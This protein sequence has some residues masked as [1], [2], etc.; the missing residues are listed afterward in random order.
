MYPYRAFDEVYRYGREANNTPFGAIASI[1]H[2]GF[3]ENSNLSGFSQVEWGLNTDG[4]YDLTSLT[5]QGQ[6]VKLKKVVTRIHDTIGKATEQLNSTLLLGL[7]PSPS[8]VK[9]KTFFDDFESM[10]PGY[11]FTTDPRNKDILKESQALFSHVF[12]SRELRTEFFE[13]SRGGVRPLRLRQYLEQ[14]VA[15]VERLLFLVHITGGQPARATELNSIH[16][17]NVTTVTRSVFWK[18]ETIV[19]NIRYNKTRASNNRD[20]FVPRFLPPEVSQLFLVY[21]VYIKPFAE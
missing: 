8:V 18:Y 16:L 11:S 14:V 21:L 2:L 1:R 5:I 9:C 17:V 19:F 13:G 3:S 4:S 10:E 6:L 15:F 20:A 7:S 12:N